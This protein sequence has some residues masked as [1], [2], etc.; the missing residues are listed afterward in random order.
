MNEYAQLSDFSRLYITTVLNSLVHR[1]FNS[2]IKSFSSIH[3]VVNVKK[4]CVGYNK[5]YFSFYFQVASYV[6][7]W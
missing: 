4:S 6:K 7:Y 1:I 2:Y 3:I 5:Y